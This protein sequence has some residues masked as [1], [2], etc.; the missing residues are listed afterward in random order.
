MLSNPSSS[1]AE[2]SSKEL[3]DVNGGIIGTIMI[4][5]GGILLAGSVKSTKA[6]V[7]IAIGTGVLAIVSELGW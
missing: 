2:L 7:G 4:V 5:A 3:I 6:A 1:F